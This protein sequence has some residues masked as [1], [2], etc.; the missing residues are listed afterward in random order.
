MHGSTYA[1][2]VVVLPL[3]APLESRRGSTT[4]KSRPPE[5]R[6]GIHGSTIVGEVILLPT[7]NNH[8]YIRLIIVA[9]PTFF[10]L[11]LVVH[12]SDIR[13]QKMMADGA[14]VDLTYQQ[15]NSMRM[16]TCFT[17]HR[18]FRCYASTITRNFHGGNNLGEL[19]RHMHAMMS[20]EPA[21]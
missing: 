2:H 13:V 16:G 17:N 4:G 20:K 18:C 7:S 10:F 19:Y 1:M 15:R 12:P 9:D 5:P 3:T 14:N 8:I 6:V 11:V 21:M